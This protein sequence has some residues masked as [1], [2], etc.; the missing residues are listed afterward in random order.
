MRAA[1]IPRSLAAGGV[2]PD[3]PCRRPPSGVRR[4]DRSRAGGPWARPT[5]PEPTATRRPGPGR[6]PTSDARACRSASSDRRRCCPNFEMVARW[7]HLRTG[8]QLGIFHLDARE[9][10]RGAQAGRL[11][12]G[13]AS[14]SRSL[15]TA[16]PS[17]S[18]RN[19]ARRPTGSRPTATS[20][21]WGR[22]RCRPSRRPRPIGS[23]SFPSK[24]LSKGDQ[25]VEPLLRP[26][27][28]RRGPALGQRRR[29]LRRQPLRAPT[30][31]PL[32]GVGRLAG[33]SSPRSGFASY[34]EPAAHR[35]A[36]A[37]CW[38][39]NGVSSDRRSWPSSV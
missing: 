22:R 9:G 20:S 24:R 25:R 28:Q 26:G 39:P 32:P 4:R 29:G 7:R 16:T 13:R 6:A 17:S 37:T 34:L 31:L 23:R 15:I 21:R 19:P 1:T 38:R 18:R 10:L 27:H 5:S 30:R 12:P 14:R 35:I 36:S 33:S 11:A 2:D 8:R 3:G